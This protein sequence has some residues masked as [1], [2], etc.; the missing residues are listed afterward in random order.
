MG[1]AIFAV[2]K[3]TKLCMKLEQCSILLT[4]KLR[5]LMGALNEDPTLRLNGGSPPAPVSC[6]RLGELLCLTMQCT[7]PSKS[8]NLS[9]LIHNLVNFQ[10]TK[11][12][13]PI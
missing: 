10:D 12:A 6:P 4:S 7:H 3:R 8:F 2:Q 5:M 1:C 11:M 9:I 13:H